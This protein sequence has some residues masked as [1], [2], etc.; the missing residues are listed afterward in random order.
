MART[1]SVCSVLLLGL[2]ATAPIACR[3]NPTTTKAQHIERG[4]AYLAEKKINEA[5]IEYR[6]AVNIDPRA[7]EARTKLGEA[8]FENRDLRNAFGEFVRAADLMPDNAEAQIRAGQVLL[9]VGQFE[10]AK[11]RADKVLA[12]DAKN[13]TAQ[14]LRGNALAGLK[15]IDGA[16]AQIE[17]AIATDPSQGINYANLGA[18]LQFAKGDAVKAEV[19]FKKAVETEPKSVA[20]RLALANL[21]WSTG[22]PKEAEAA[23]AETLV[24]EPRNVMANRALAIFYLGSGR[25]AQAE[26]PLKVLAEDVPGPDGQMALADYYASIRRAPEAKAIFEKLAGASETEAKA[27]LR[28]AALAVQEGNRAEAYRFIGEIL[29]KQPKHPDALTARALLEFED[30]K[31][32]E[33]LTTI[34]A[35]VAANPTLA[36]GQFVLGRILAATNHADEAMSAYHEA[37]R[38]NPR[39]AAAE[40]ELARLSLQQLKYVDAIQFAQGALNSAPGYAEAHL[41]LAR[42][43]IA[44]GD[45][46]TAEKQL[47]ELTTAYPQVPSL[48]SEVGRLR[49]AKGDSA[50]ARAAFERALATDPNQVNAIDGLIS[51]DVNQKRNQAARARLDAA[52]K[53]S[54]QNPALQ[55]VAA[56]QYS[57]LGDDAAAEKSVKQAITLDAKNLAAYDLLARI[58][59]QQRKLPEAT[60]EFDKLATMQ[61]RASGPQTAVGVFLQIQNRFDEAETRYKKALEIDPRAAV[62]ANNLA[63]M[64]ADRDGDLDLALQLAQTAK[65]ALPNV[66]E[67]D[68]TLGWIYYKKRLSSVAIA[69]LNMSVAAQPSNPLY[70]YHL[71]LAQA[72][73]GD[74]NLAR[75]SLEKALRGGTSTGPMTHVACW[76]RSE[77]DELD[78]GG[79]AESS[80]GRPQPQ[81]RRHGATG[82]RA[83]RAFARRIA[84]HDLLSRRARFVGARS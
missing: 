52:V 55:L 7:G 47:R 33:A 26:Q 1:T 49:M 30:G 23:L 61:P 8:Y 59:V 77:T 70:L 53:A 24:I 68:D 32:E 12:N 60:A 72:Q 25:T 34:R 66:S 81:S 15:D 83:R 36:Q 31:S 73:N 74:N 13:V 22:R 67:V 82:R 40:L 50:G 42:A 6:N 35:G 21:Y 39:F 46:Q 10:D 17:G 76:P 16:L 80:P 20:A 18:I 29:A 54:P 62:A 58:Y 27:R 79:D 14:I 45:P 11:T 78:T 3:S 56:R 9:L 75:K 51:L 2:L 41:I 57:A 63:Q 48:Q 37:V 71:G 64:Y 4:D 44:N 65:A 84:D 28:L 43:L 69:S 5:I 38:L 19:A